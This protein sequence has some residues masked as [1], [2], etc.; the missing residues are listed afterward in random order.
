MHLLDVIQQEEKYL[1]LGYCRDCLKNKGSS[2][3]LSRLNIEISSSN[4]KLYWDVMNQ[5]SNIKNYDGYPYFLHILRCC[6]IFININKEDEINI[7]ETISYILVHD[8]LEEGIKEHSDWPHHINYLCEKYNKDIANATVILT[9]PEIVQSDYLNEDIYIIKKVG[10]YLHMKMANKIEY[11]ISFLCDLI[12]NIIALIRSEYYN[13]QNCDSWYKLVRRI[14][15][16]EYMIEKFS[17]RKYIDFVRELSDLVSLLMNKYNV[18]SCDVNKMKRNYYYIEDSYGL[19][20]E[21]HILCKDR[22][23]NIIFSES[24]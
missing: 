1:Y 22:E 10:L 14:A 19:R 6:L 20:I 24:M 15:C 11:N 8:Y 4:K 3:T 13:I 18:D 9:E 5:M 12:D 2:N 16:C 21:Q 7:H 23:Y 17:D